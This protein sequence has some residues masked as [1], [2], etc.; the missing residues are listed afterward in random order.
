L[1]EFGRLAL[2]QLETARVAGVEVLQLKALAFGD[3]ERVKLLL[4]PVQDLLSRHG[5]TSLREATL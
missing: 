4:D 2:V 1:E 5:A 3:A